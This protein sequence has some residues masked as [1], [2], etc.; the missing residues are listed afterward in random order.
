[1]S[2]GGGNVDVV[3]YDVEEFDIGKLYTKKKNNYKNNVR[4]SLIRLLNYSNTTTFDG[5][6]QKCD[7]E[8]CLVAPSLSAKI[9][10]A[11]RYLLLRL[12]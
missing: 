11:N 4:Q 6:S 10:I 9:L 5:S 8:C 2:S 1:M 12:F 7:V 3:R